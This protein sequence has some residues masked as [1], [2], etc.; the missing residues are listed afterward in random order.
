MS[1]VLGVD[2]GG[3][4]CRAL[5]LDARR[6][7]VWCGQSGAANLAS[8]PE[9]LL[10]EN[11]AHLLQG[12]PSAE[13]VV[14]CFA[15]ALTTGDFARGEALIRG[16]MPASRIVVLPDYAAAVRASQPRYHLVAVLGTGS[17]VASRSRDGFHRSGG[18][19]Y[20]LGDEA[21]GFRLGALALRAWLG[22]PSSVGLGIRRA[23]RRTFGSADRAEVV[24]KCYRPVPAVASIASLAPFALASW[25]RSEQPLADAVDRE[26][27]AF[28][29]VVV[30]HT[31]RY[32][33]AGP[34]LRIA[35][36]GGLWKASPH[37]MRAVER[38]VQ[39]HLPEHRVSFARLRVE[40]VMGAALLALDESQR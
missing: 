24:A 3:T 25:A 26:L 27:D 33:A 37:L 35:G 5:A 20:L 34:T 9:A 32:V 29:Q 2:A 18:N 19:G 31:R 21:S 22:D 14:G 4:S 39:A 36:A 38:R 12:A 17:I 13:V 6:R 11:L 23:M 40:P 15:G 16:T 30:C 1:I 7:V 28:A 10:R 8:T